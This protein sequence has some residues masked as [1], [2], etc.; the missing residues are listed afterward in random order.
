MLV[1][2]RHM[3]HENHANDR[4]TLGKCFKNKIYI[5]CMRKNIFK[6]EILN[7]VLVKEAADKNNIIQTFI[8]FSTFFNLLILLEKLIF[9]ANCWNVL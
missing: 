8:R 4:F 5:I 2:Y 9:C 1:T 3:S 7:I 6:I